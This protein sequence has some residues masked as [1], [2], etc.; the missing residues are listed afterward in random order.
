MTTILLVDDDRPLLRALSLGIAAHGYEVI[1]AEDGAAAIRAA[2]EH[3]P[4]VVLLDLGLP[5]MSGVEVITALR[6]W[7]SVPIVVLSA[8][9]QSATKVA[10]L[11]AGADDYLT[12]PF[13]MDE[14][15]ARVRAVL[16]RQ[17]PDDAVIVHAGD[18]AINLAEHRVARAGVDVHLTPKEWSVLAVLARHPERLVTQAELLQKVWGPEYGAESDYLR[19]LFARLRRKLEDDPASPRHLITE[20]G[21]GYRL[22]R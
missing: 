22:E 1:T 12:K 18:L 11:D 13:G 15:L 2:V 8:R 17:R 16:R 10:A 6:G 5:K 9:H 14:L 19:T 7:S 4:D 21:V 3:R 20:P